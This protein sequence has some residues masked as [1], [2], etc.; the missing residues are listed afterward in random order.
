M[1]FIVYK[2]TNKINGKFYIGKHQTT[3]LNDGYFGSGK[4]LKRAIK[5][6]GKENFLSEILHVF[7]TEE[8]MNQKEKELVIIGKMSYNLCEGGKGGFGYINRKVLTVEDR[9]KN[10]SI[11]GK[12]SGS[13]VGKITGKDNVTKKRGLFS[14]EY[15]HLRDSWRRNNKTTKGK[16]WINNGTYQ[17]L[18]EKNKIPEGWDIGRL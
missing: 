5:K 12:L 7:Q 18:T 9:R 11:G 3:D 17:T 10:G 6:Y 2:T 8:E 13:K 1:Y 4:L 16:I 15:D 14:S